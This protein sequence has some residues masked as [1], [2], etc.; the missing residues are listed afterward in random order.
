MKTIGIFLCAFLWTGVTAFAQS[1]KL[2]GLQFDN[3]G[4]TSALYP[5][6]AD[7][8]SGQLTK[9][10]PTPASSDQ[11]SSGNSTVDPGNYTYHYIRGM[12][13]ILISVNYATG[14]VS[15][16]AINN[17]NN[18][19]SPITSIQYNP[20]DGYIYGL[21]MEGNNLRFA[22]MN[23]ANGQ[24]TLVN[25]NPISQAGFSSGNA[26]I[27]PITGTYY[28]VRGSQTHQLVRVN[29]QTGTSTA[30]AITNPNQAI[31]PITSIQWNPAD[32]MIYGLN[33]ISGELRLAKMN[34]ATGS[35]TVI[36]SSAISAD[37]FS[38]GVS[39]LNVYAQTYSYVRGY[40]GAQQLIEVD[41]TTGLV[42][43][44]PSLNVN[45]GSK[46]LTNIEWLPISSAVSRFNAPTVCGNTQV[47]FEDLS[48]ADQVSWDFGDEN[49]STSAN[50][51]HTYASPGTYTVRQIVSTALNSD[52]SYQTIQ[53]LPGINLDLGADIMINP[54]DSITL[55]A[56]TTGAVSYLWNTA[57]TTPTIEVTQTG[58]YSCTI[59][60]AA[61]CIGS[62][63]IEVT[64]MIAFSIDD[65]SNTDVSASG[66]AQELEAIV[67]IQNHEATSTTYAYEINVELPDGWSQDEVCSGDMEKLRF[68]RIRL[69]ANSGGGFHMIFNTNGLEGTAQGT[70]TLKN[71][72]NAQ[73]V[74]VSDFSVRNTSII[75]SVDELNAEAFTLYPNPAQAGTMI[76][77]N[78]EP[79][80]FELYSINGA[81]IQSGM[82]TAIEAPSSPGMYF[83]Q[84]SDQIHRIV[85]SN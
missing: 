40:P 27:D 83:L 63:S 73:V 12:N 16:N 59:R 66:T 76:K 56:T 82:N 81:L 85:V 9:L 44:S 52:T 29:S 80:S 7:E 10:N 58:T 49:Q 68:N 67:W 70:L 13:P 84:T 3:S 77:I 47:T 34:P 28:Y 11:F 79:I 42:Q 78:D 46:N 14:A 18:A 43:S 53:I 24:V 51:S 31:S 72:V 74:R 61:D 48:L 19:V 62:D 60:N 45:Q 20:I 8:A 38:S 6:F 32:S 36:S 4:T 71:T 41:L 15:V 33:F 26:T 57:A 50:P 30:V 22:K 5:V 65:F 2:I 25:S 23:P 69:N 1:G 35:V 37:M 17:P 39:A 75:S 55:D 21:N 64:P 54:G